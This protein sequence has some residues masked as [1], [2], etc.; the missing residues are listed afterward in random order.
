M[1]PQRTLGR[2]ILAKQD[3]QLSE[4]AH[5]STLQAQTSLEK[6]DDLLKVTRV[7]IHADEG[8]ELLLST[9]QKGFLL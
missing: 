1:N 3:R 2:P 9:D 4:D 7:L 5:V 6:V 8:R